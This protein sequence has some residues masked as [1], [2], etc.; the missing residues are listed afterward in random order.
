MSIGICARRLKLSF[1][2]RLLLRASGLSKYIFNDRFLLATSA[3]Y[4]QLSKIDFCFRYFFFSSPERASFSFRFYSA[5]SVVNEFRRCCECITRDR[6][7]IGGEKYKIYIYKR[8]LCWV[9]P[10]CV[11]NYKAIFIDGQY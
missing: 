10:S 11:F 6:G 5:R 9:C 7:K 2:E 4:A 3:I 1:G 8:R